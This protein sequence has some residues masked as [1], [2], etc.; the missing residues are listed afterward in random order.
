METRKIREEHELWHGGQASI[1]FGKIIWTKGY[2]CYLDKE[3]IIDIL[4]IEILKKIIICMEKI[5]D[6]N[7]N[8]NTNRCR[9][10]KSVRLL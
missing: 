6:G 2:G 8:K 4:T 10:R 9:F 1:P 7:K 3:K 5:E